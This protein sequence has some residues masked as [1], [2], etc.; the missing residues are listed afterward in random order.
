MPTQ[1]DEK[2]AFAAGVQPRRFACERCHRHKLKCERGPTSTN[3]GLATPIDPC[4]RCDR[5]G[6]PCIARKSTSGPGRRKKNPNANPTANPPP[7][8]ARLIQKPKTPES[9]DHQPT[10]PANNVRAMSPFT[11]SMFEVES[12]LTDSALYLDAFDIDMFGTDRDCVDSSNLSSGSSPGFPSPEESHSTSSGMSQTVEAPKPLDID[13]SAGVSDDLF[14][15]SMFLS[16]APTE[17][18]F[19]WNGEP[20]QLSTTEPTDLSNSP[21]PILETM[22]R[23]SEMQSTINKIFV[24]ISEENLATTFLTPGT[25]SC[26]CA[27]NSSDDENLVGKVVHASER[28]IEILTSPGINELMSPSAPSLLGLRSDNCVSRKRAQSTLLDD[29][30]FILPTVEPYESS[31]FGS[32][33]SPS[34]RTSSK[35]IDTPR[36]NL[37]SS[38]GWPTPASNRASSVGVDS[39]TYSGLLSPAKLTLMVCHVTLLGVYRSILSQAFNLLRTPFPPTPLPS[40]QTL[41]SSFLNEASDSSHSQHCLQVSTSTALGFRIQLEIIAHT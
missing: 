18:Y 25:G 21:N 22:N 26:H 12:T 11:K 10:P 3:S 27:K 7:V 9:M 6:V 8:S 29:D 38:S 40:P 23:L 33:S 5:A 20:S 16:P 41:R 4:K 2:V 34:D 39:P 13:F 1:V 14:A 24:S 15:K 35:Y 30:E 17:T 28:M 36:T 32:L 37:S 19:P 31:T